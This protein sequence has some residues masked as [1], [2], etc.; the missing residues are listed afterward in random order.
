MCGRSR[1]RKRRSS[2][3]EM[4]LRLDI[5]RKFAGSDDESPG[6]FRMGVTS[7][8]L[9][10]AGKVPCENERFASLAMS[11]EKTPEHDLIS[12]VGT[13]SRADDLA[14]SELRMPKTSLGVTGES[15]SRVGPV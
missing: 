11:M 15:K 6:F 4:L 10:E 13:K 14:G 2:I 12:D 3:L 5:G 1:E 7:A 8:C 9:K